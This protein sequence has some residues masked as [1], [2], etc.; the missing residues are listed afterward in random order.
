[1]QTHEVTALTQQVLWAAFAL[2][3]VFGAIVQRTQFCTM[4][5]VSDVVVMGDWTRMRQWG[6]A[7]GVVTVGFAVL[8]FA[9]LVN[10]AKTLYFSTRWLWLSGAVGGL[11][12]GAGM[13]LS[14]GCGSKSLVRVGA[15][16][17]KS[18][19][20]LLVM[21]CAGFATLKGISAVARVA[22]VDRVA[23]EFPMGASLPAVLASATALDG[24]MVALALAL[25][26]GG[27][28]I[29]WSLAGPGFWRFNNLLA[30]LGIGGVVVAMWWA[31]GHM[32]FVSEHPETLQ[33]AYLATNSGR[34]EAMSFVAPVSYA[35]DWLLFFSDKSKVLTVGIVA[36]AGTVLGSTIS[37]CWSKTFRWEGFANTEDLANHLVGGLLMGV[38]GITAMGCT[39]G[40][41]LSGASTLSLTSLVALAAIILGSVLALRYQNWRLDRSP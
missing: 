25:L 16:N 40:Q 41:G 11:L 24:S 39:V 1:M 19:V 13:V 18:L 10:P 3:L 22:S 2:S 20:V 35:L 21:A 27:G 33:E 15:G 23:V 4:G 34:A 17:L 6:L 32:G 38:G 29:A 36:V 7:L 12:F 30:G 14:S 37:A 28:L 9:G 26:V 8:V 5:A 31:S